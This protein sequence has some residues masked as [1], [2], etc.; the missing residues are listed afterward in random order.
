[1]LAIGIDAPEFMMAVFRLLSA[2]ASDRM[3]SFVSIVALLV[4]SD[5]IPHSLPNGV[6]VPV[7]PIDCVTML[8]LTM[9]SLFQKHNYSENGDSRA[10]R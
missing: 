10:K 7:P 5:A 3:L 1:V 9:E 2:L 6:G 8:C 4:C